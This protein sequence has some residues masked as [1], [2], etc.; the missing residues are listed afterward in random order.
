MKFSN[1]FGRT[2]RDDQREADVVSHNLLLRAGYV[3]QLASGIFSYL[4]FGQKSMKKIEAIIREEMDAIGGDEIVMPIVHPAE[5]WQQT[6]R[7][8]DIDESMVRFKDR[9]DRDMVL[10]MTHEEV[11]A[12]LASKE[13]ETYK[14]LPKLVYQVYTKFRDEVRSRGGLIRVREF[15]MKDSYSLDRDMQGLQQQ[16]TAHYEA[17]FRIFRRA[18]LPSVAILSDTGMMGGRKAHEYMYLT[19][20]GEDTIFICEESGYMA[21]KEIAAFRKTYKKEL[22]KEIKKVLTPEKSTIADLAEFLEVKE[23]DTAKIVFFF[24]NVQG[25]DKLIV[26]VVRGDM[27]ANP[28]KIQNI[29][30]AKGMRVASSE[31]ITAVNAVPGYASPIGIDREKAIVIVDDWIANSN[32]LVTGANEPNYHYLNSCYGRDYKADSIGDIVSAYEGAPCPVSEGDYKLKSVRG[33]EIGNIFQLGTRYTSAM[34]AFY[35]D[36]DGKAK[37]IFMG[38][39]GIGVGRMLA[40]LAEEHN[41][42]QGLYLPISIAP[43]EVIIVGLLDNEEVETAAEELYRDLRAEGIEVIYDNRD[44]KSASAGVK[45]RDAELIGIPIRLTASKRSLKEGAFELKMRRGEGKGELIP[46]DK[47]VEEV[48]K[49]IMELHVNL[50][51]SMRPKEDF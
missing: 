42:E 45:F 33:I 18:G 13:I 46:Q 23:E 12:T 15:T 5:I 2:L 47:V 27:E 48:K 29:L 41:D 32:N 35:N 36:I 31:E 37:P 34:G 4:H 16:Y 28:N 39:Y 25:E 20:I 6:G 11:V 9:G 51:E 22:P 44:S 8:Y 38:S 43:Y 21:N 49:R 26:A 17:Y 3:R 7:W 1:L 24:G 14:Q 19:P 40:C 10:A 30:G 50:E